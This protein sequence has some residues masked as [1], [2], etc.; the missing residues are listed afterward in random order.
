LGYYLRVFGKNPARIPLEKL[1]AD[2][3]RSGSFL[4]DLKKK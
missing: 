3:S 4:P 1:R 2:E